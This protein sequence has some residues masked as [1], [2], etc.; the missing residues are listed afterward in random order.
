MVFVQLASGDSIRDIEAC[1]SANPSKFYRLGIRCRILR[2][3]LADANERRD[4]RIF[5]EFGTILIAEARRLYAEEAFFPELNA[6]VYALDSATVTLYL[7]PFPWASGGAAYK[8]S[9]TRNHPF[10][11]RTEVRR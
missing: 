4:A 10:E 1:L 6:A 5:E 3:T 2:S 8:K 9:A 7:E 11:S